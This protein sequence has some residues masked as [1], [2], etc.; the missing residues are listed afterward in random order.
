VSNTQGSQTAQPWLQGMVP[1][2]AGYPPVA[3]SSQMASAQQ[4]HYQPY[5][6]PL[7]PTFPNQRQVMQ[8]PQYG[9]SSGQPAP[10]PSL[11]EQSLYGQ[12]FYG[13]RAYQPTSHEQVA[14][15]APPYGR[16]AYGQQPHQ[17]TAMP[18][19]LPQLPTQY[20]QNHGSVVDLKDT[21]NSVSTYH[22]DVI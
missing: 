11:Y 8:N 2:D 9:P 6:T 17:E 14:Y 16:T 3:E 22:P 10:R 5:P 21:G 7:V 18:I 1:P 4:S 12:P 13:Q 20:E 19:P 15:Q